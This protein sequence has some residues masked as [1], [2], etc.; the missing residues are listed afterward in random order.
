M[1]HHSGLGSRWTLPR[2]ARL[3]LAVLA[4]Q[5]CSSTSNGPDEAT[6]GTSGSGGGGLGGT[7][8]TTEAGGSAAGQGGATGSGGTA[9][10]GGPG[11]GSDT[12]GSV[13]RGGA[14]RPDGAVGT[15]GTP[16]D[17]G[18]SGTGGARNRGGAMGRGGATGTGGSRANG[19]TN[20]SGGATA[21]G[22][23]SG[24]AG[25]T[26]AAN[27]PYKGVANS[28]ASEIAA[29]GATWCYN[30][31]TSPKAS[32]CSDPYFVPMIWGGGDVA[33][34]IKAIGRAGYQTVLGF[35]EPNKSDQA[36]LSV[37]SAIALWPDLTSDPNIRVGS[38]AVSDDG[39]AWLESFMTKAQ[40]QG[41]RVDFIAM[42]WYGW[43]AGSC[44]P[45]QLEGAINWA[46]KW[47]LPI[48]I[49]EFGCMGSSNTDEQTVIDFFNNAIPML[50]KHPLVERYAW[51][52]WNKYNDLY[53]AGSDGTRTIT[54]LGKAFAAAPQYHP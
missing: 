33:G 47:N 31:G 3:A 54:A 49:T 39:R 13:G 43:N 12:G 11:V 4:A 48:W 37:D 25:A 51:Y 8:R 35:N 27:S 52:P 29:L 23:S 44:V 2:A 24:S 17:A 7:S 42:H 46:S 36:N 28:P 50:K 45:S 10:A 26:T 5:A 1:N 19:G 14:M 18:A 15:G 41:L 21:L 30:W 53:L 40:A 9:T 32:D 22:G 16:R 38:P 6:G 20:G 34:T